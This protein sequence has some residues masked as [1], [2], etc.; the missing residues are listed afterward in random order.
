MRP[1]LFAAAAAFGSAIMISGCIPSIDEPAVLR[2]PQN[3]GANGDI[4]WMHVRN[5]FLVSGMDTSPA[6]GTRSVRGSR[7]KSGRAADR[8]PGHASDRNSGRDSGRK[9]GLGSDRESSR[10]SERG[11]GHGSDRESSRESER[12]SG[13]ASDR[14][15]GRKSGRGSSVAARSRPGH[16]SASRPDQALFAVLTSDHARPDRLERV[17]V[18]GGGSVRLAGLIEIHQRQPAGTA[19]Q[20][21]GTATGVRA[22]GSVP[23]TFI[24]R[25]AGTV[26][27]MVPVI[28][29]VGRYATL[30]PS[31]TAV[32]TS[33]P[34]PRRP[35]P[36]PKP[37]PPPQHAT[38]TP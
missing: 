14:E 15:S 23:M 28:A 22:G 16:R 31:P 25:D 2:R 35:G 9:P 20:P 32:S 7:H 11:S 29:R 24:F 8:K 17:T 34:S 1:I 18:E 27:V 10:E 12:G 26:R 33:T 38:R 3:D 19:Q 21:I 6:S 30:P 13:R 5:A 36:S 4:R 37:T